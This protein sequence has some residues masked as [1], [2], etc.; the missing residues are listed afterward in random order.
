M[1]DGIGG[2]TGKSWKFQVLQYLTIR[3]WTAFSRLNWWLVLDG[4][5]EWKAAN[6][7]IQ[8]NEKAKKEMDEQERLKHFMRVDK[9]KQ[10]KLKQMQ[11]AAKKNRGI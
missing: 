3:G 8:L 4:W 7:S 2:D 11:E 5:T 6:K 9:I 1:V 10:Q